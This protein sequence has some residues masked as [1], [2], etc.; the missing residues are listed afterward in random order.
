VLSLSLI[1]KI[2]FFTLISVLF[3]VLTYLGYK[4]RNAYAVPLW[5]FSSFLHPMEF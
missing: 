5:G 2:A 4:V 1:A 3:Y